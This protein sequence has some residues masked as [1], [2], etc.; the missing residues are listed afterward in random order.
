MLSIFIVRGYYCLSNIS[1]FTCVLYLGAV[2]VLC[3]AVLLVD[4]EG[5][6]DIKME[7]QRSGCQNQSV[8]SDI[9]NQT[10]G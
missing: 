7:K 2:V 5:M 10:A 4:E 6:E 9:Q 3:H 1:V 8:L